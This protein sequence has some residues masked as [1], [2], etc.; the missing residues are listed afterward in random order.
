MGWECFYDMASVTTC[1]GL[2]SV[3]AFA[4]SS[5]EEDLPLDFFYFFPF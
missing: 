2:F 4:V 1:L 5:E 3:L